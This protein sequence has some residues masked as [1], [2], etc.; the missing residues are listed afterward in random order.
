MNPLRPMPDPLAELV[1]RRLHVLGHS[2]RMRLIARLGC[3]EAESVQS[4]AAALGI[5]DYNASQHLGV[6]RE[7]GVVR[8]RQ[9]GRTAYYSLVDR[10]VI[11]LYDAVGRSIAQQ[12]RRVGE[13]L[14]DTENE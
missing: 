6:L 9:Q 11:D 8:R 4:L 10:S 7:A 12:L 3:S 2:T 14:G 13:Q 1:A 5:S